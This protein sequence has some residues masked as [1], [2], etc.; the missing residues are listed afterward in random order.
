MN[1]TIDGI[2]DKDYL[3]SKGVD[4]SLAAILLSHR[5]WLKFISDNREELGESMLNVGLSDDSSSHSWVSFFLN[6]LNFKNI[7]ILEFHKPNYDSIVE[8][9]KDNENVKVILGDVRQA[10]DL[11]KE[12]SDFCFWWHGP[13]HIPE[14]D[15]PKA[16]GELK[17][18]CNKAILW[19]C[20]WG[21]YYANGPGNY[22]GD[23]HHFYPENEHFTSLGMQVFNTGGEKNTGGANISAYLFKGAQQW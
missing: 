19:A 14:E 18:L 11:V 13:E 8:K 2:F 21:S 17:S 7:T 10:S 15:L 20:P 5:D 12:T 9:F 16:L 3:I 23:G 6:V 1:K 22:L 4:E